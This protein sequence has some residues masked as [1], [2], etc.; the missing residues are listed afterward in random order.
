VELCL[1]SHLPEVI[2]PRMSTNKTLEKWERQPPK[3]FSKATT[4]FLQ[5][6]EA[7]VGMLPSK[8]FK[9]QERQVF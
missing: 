7:E 5:Y 1:W 9:T 8:Y 6:I 2:N 3:E 4:K